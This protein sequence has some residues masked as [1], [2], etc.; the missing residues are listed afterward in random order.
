MAID[1]Y[2]KLRREVARLQELISI[3]AVES[4][5]KSNDPPPRRV[6]AR[7][8]I[9][10][11]SCVSWL[12]R[13]TGDLIRAAVAIRIKNEDPSRRRRQDRP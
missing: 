3:L 5:A 10:L 12:Q 6:Q 13:A 7:R 11:N 2:T 9:A 1:S 4:D 8:V